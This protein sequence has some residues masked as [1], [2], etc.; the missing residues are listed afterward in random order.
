VSYSQGYAYQ[1]DKLAGQLLSSSGPL[2]SRTSGINGSIKDIGV[3]RD[4]MSLRLND[5]EKRYR[6]QFTALDALVSQLRATSDFLTRQLA[7]L[8]PP[9]GSTNGR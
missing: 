7:I 3:E 5:I 9:G 2:E 6:A 4:A 1:L 8:P